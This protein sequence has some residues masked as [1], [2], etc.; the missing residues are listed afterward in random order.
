MLKKIIEALYAIPSDIDRDQWIRIGMAL[1]ADGEE[2]DIFD[3]WSKSAQNYRQKD[4]LSAWK[5]FKNG[6]VGIGTL[7]Y[8]ARQYG[9]EET[10]FPKPSVSKTAMP[11]AECFLD[12]CTPA[13]SDHPYFRA[14][15]I[16]PHVYVWIDKNN[17]LVIPVFD[18]R[19][20]VKSLQFISPSGKKKFM[21]GGPIKGNFHQILAGPEG[22]IICEGYA[23]G[24]T[25]AQNYP[26]NRSVIVAFN[27]GN[28]LAVA[29]VFRQAYPDQNI[30]IAG[31]NDASGVGQKKATEAAL[32]IAGNVSI[33][34]FSSS[35]KG[36]DWNDRWLLDNLGGC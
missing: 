11:N 10:S 17:N 21:K 15:N 7:F 2:F 6:A 27:A 23:T 16:R 35:E 13:P 31:D 25:L 14:K 12:S 33:P 29:H 22:I 20:E 24:V 32:A 18:F 28:L 26:S 30:I 5:S 9:W 36:S 1:K 34:Q 8:I 4:A 19:R 3:S